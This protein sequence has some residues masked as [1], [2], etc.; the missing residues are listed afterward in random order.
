M[1]LCPCGKVYALELEQYLDGF[2]APHFDAAGMS[3]KVG[4]T[5]VEHRYIRGCVCKPLLHLNLQRECFRLPGMN[6]SIYAN[7]RSKW[8]LAQPKTASKRWQPEAF[9]LTLPS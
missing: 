1:I 5:V 3:S 4:R 9:A 8:W 2:A 7:C 6:L